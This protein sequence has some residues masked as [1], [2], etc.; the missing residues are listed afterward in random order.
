MQTVLI[1]GATSDIAVAIARQFASHGADVQL[2]A[3][4]PEHLAPLASDLRIR[5][6]VNATTYAFDAGDFAA[7]GAFYQALTPR[8]DVTICVFG[9]M[10][11][12]D[13]A[14]QDWQVALR[15]MHTNYVGAV[16]ILNLVA[17]D[18]LQRRAGV[19]VGLSSVA[20]ERGRAS[21]LIYGSSKAALSAYLSGLR[22][23][24]APS[25][26]HVL[27]VKPGFVSTRMTAGMDLPPL[28]TATPEQVALAV[29][30]AVMRRKNTLYVKWLWR[31]IMLVIRLI[32]EPLFKKLHL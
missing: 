20:G 4:H 11:D 5:Y 28:L 12:E 22:N 25:G 13:V 16:S 9:A 6:G 3:R 26:V 23:K 29:Y 2:A 8:P 31:W 1:L 14:A 15:M 32:P 7:H 10:E 19:I 17:H 21:K 30:N 24:L 27:S 18:Y